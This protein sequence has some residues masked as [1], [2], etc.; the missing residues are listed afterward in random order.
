MNT[1]Q[2]K[3][4][5]TIITIN[6]IL[7]ELYTNKS[8]DEFRMKGDITKSPS[9][10]KI[11]EMIAD[12]ST[13]KGFSKRD[14]SDIKTMFNTLHRPIFKTMVKEYIMEPNDRNMVYCSM[15]TIGY[16]LIV[17]ELSRIFASTEAT[18]KGIVYKPD[19][20]SRKE[21]A[22]KMIRVY[23]DQ[24]EAKLDAYVKDLHKAPEASSPVNESFIQMLFEMDQPKHCKECDTVKKVESVTEDDASTDTA[25]SNT[26]DV[27][28]DSS[29]TTG[30]TSVDDTTN[31]DDTVQEAAG[32][33]ISAGAKAVGSF[34]KTGGKKIA[35]VISGIGAIG[36]IFSTI[37]SIFAGVNPIADVNFL[38]MESY[39]KKIAKLDAVSRMYEETKKAYQ[40]YMKIPD[41]KRSKKVES[42]YIQNIA[43]Y[44]NAMKTLSAEIAHYDQRALKESQEAVADVEKSIPTGTPDT[45]TS[46]QQT[47]DD[48]F[49]F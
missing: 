36:G 3:L 8:T 23:N 2:K 4:D 40:E 28:N 39:E 31:S 30:D 46:T 42:K 49:Q 44:N 45:N 16:R 26:S 43:K 48:D 47:T 9:Y 24:I 18:E 14:A 35:L 22:T 17:G 37:N 32:A 19:R 27:A 25:P 29:E 13:L 15:F 6:S 41:A 11:E 10:G 7:R 5:A 20:N 12:L 33:A 38:M 34:L 21:A 1:T